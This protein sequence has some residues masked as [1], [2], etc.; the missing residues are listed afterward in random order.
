MASMSCVPRLVL[1]GSASD[2]GIRI[3]N[4][5]EIAKAIGADVLAAFYKC[6]AGSDRLMTLEHLVF[7]SDEEAVKE[8]DRFV[9]KPWQGHD[10]LPDDVS[11]LF[12]E[13]LS[14]AEIVVVDERNKMPE[15]P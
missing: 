12:R 10:E 2:W 7:I 5:R 4:P 14:G 3:E 13:V 9:K 11:R 1:H 8:F 6:F 15:E